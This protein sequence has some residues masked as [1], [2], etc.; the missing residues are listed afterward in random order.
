[1]PNRAKSFFLCYSCSFYPLCTLLLPCYSY[2]KTNFSRFQH[3]RHNCFVIILTK[4]E[5]SQTA[6]ICLH[7][8][9]AE[10]MP[11]YE[12]ILFLFIGVL[13]RSYSDTRQNS[14]ET[15]STVNCLKFLYVCKRNNNMYYQCKTRTMKNMFSHTDLVIFIKSIGKRSESRMPFKYGS[16]PNS[17]LICPSPNK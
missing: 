1:M 17:K 7:L 14:Y 2:L 13:S 9:Q 10:K 4:L 6:I 5:T 15:F 8:S 16:F 3:I 11:S 12:S